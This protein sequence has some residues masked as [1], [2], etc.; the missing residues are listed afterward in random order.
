MK[1][2]L[3]TIVSLILVSLFL[4]RISATPALSAEDISHQRNKSRISYIDINQ[5]FT[6]L[7]TDP[8]IALIHIDRNR[9]YYETVSGEQVSK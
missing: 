4:V 5:M 1:I 2:R 3:K 8:L 7:K 9:I 6:S